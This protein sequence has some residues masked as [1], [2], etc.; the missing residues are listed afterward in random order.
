MIA[1]GS[2][3]SIDR[4]AGN[5]GEACSLEP[6]AR[7]QNLGYRLLLLTGLFLWLGGR[8]G[9]LLLLIGILAVLGD[10]LSVVDDL[11]R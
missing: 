2:I 1:G 8:R 10:V 5:K 11:H 7:G 3:C 9:L 6:V 4:G